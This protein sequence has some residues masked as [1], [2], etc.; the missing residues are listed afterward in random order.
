M[1]CSKCGQ[2][3]KAGV[4]FCPK[5]GNP[6]SGGIYQGYQ[7]VVGESLNMQAVKKRPPYLAIGAIVIVVLIVILLVKGIFFRSTYETPVKNMVKAMEDRDAQAV[8][9]LLPPKLL[10]EA[11]E[12]LGMDTD[13]LADY[14]ESYVSDEFEE[15]IGDI[16]VSYKITNAI[17]MTE[18]EIEETE[19]YFQG[20]LGDI[21]EGKKLDISLKVKV[22][23]EEEEE[24]EMEFEVIKVDG[25]WY[26]NPRNLF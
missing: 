23:G 1:F 3:I 7:D 20:Y 15:G 17:D 12:K 10:E 11:K 16:K 22:E 26:I 18:E 13:E 4:R 8:L 25:K 5:C 19:Q 9:E 24:T 21:K 14:A 6:V 2:E